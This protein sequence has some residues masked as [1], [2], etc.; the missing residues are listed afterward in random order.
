MSSSHSRAKS[1]DLFSDLSLLFFSSIRC[2]QFWLWWLQLDNFDLYF[3]GNTVTMVNSNSSALCLCLRCLWR[4]RLHVSSKGSYSWRTSEMH[5]HVSPLSS[6]STSLRTRENAWWTSLSSW[7]RPHILC[8]RSVILHC[9]IYRLRL[10]ALHVKQSTI[11]FVFAFHFG[12]SLSEIDY[13]TM[14]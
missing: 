5:I 8:L 3:L 4:G 1:V 12:A 9:S 11:V 10:S 2:G 14:D 6:P 13:I 7:T